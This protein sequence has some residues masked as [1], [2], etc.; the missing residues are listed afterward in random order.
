[1]PAP[2]VQIEPDVSRDLESLCTNWLQKRPEHRT[3][4]LNDL[5]AILQNHQGGHSSKFCVSCG[6]SIN[7]QSDFCGNCGAQQNIQHDL[8]AHCLACGNPVGSEAECQSCHRTFI[9]SNPCMHGISGSL[10][11]HVFRIPIGTFHVGRL[12][13]S[14][15]D[16]TISRQHFLIENLNG[17]GIYISDANS[18]N[19]TQIANNQINR[20]TQLTPGCA[21]HLAANALI[22]RTA[23]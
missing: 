6:R 14:P 8:P 12:E 17:S 9:P 7:P 5:R 4:S 15:K 23:I 1:M 10:F 2:L 3:G 18:A 13:I 16:F 22:Y 19:G 20:R 11:G 21:V